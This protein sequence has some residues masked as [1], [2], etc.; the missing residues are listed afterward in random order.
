MDYERPNTL[1]GVHFGP[2]TSCGFDIGWW[3]NELK[4]MG[5]GWIKIVD[6]AGSMYNFAKACRQ[7]G[8][9]P[10]MRMYRKWPN[11]GV[12]GTKDIEAIHIYVR[13]GITRWIEPNNEGNIPPEWAND[14]LPQPIETAA[15]ICAANW[16]IDAEKIIEL[17]GYPGIPALA[18]CSH[19]GECSSIRFSIAFFDWL[20]TNADSRMA[21]VLDHGAWLAVH[22]A[23]LNHAWTD[24]QGWHFEHPYN[25]GLTPFDDDNSLVGYIVPRDLIFA[26]WQRRIP[27]ISTEGGVFHIFRQWD[28]SYPNFVRNSYDHGVW[29]LEM[30]KWLDEWQKTHLW[31]YGMCEWLIGQQILGHQG[32]WDEESWYR[33]GEVRPVVQML[34]DNPPRR[35]DVP[36]PEP[37]PVPIPVPTPI[38]TPTPT[39]APEGFPKPLKNNSLGIH[40]GLGTRLVGAELDEDIVRAKAMR[41][42][43]GTIAF[44]AGE[45]VMLEAAKKLWVAGIMPIVRKVMNISGGYAFG[46]DTQMLVN[47]GIPA[48]VQ[49]FNEPSDSREWESERKQINRY[50][51]NGEVTT[52]CEWWVAGAREVI[53]AGGYPGFQCLH[54][55]ELDTLFRVLPASD[56]IWKRMWFCSHNYGLNH[57]PSWEGNEWGVMGFLLFAEKFQ[58]QLGFV[59]PIICGEG[60]WLWK[61]SDDSNYPMVDDVLHA[62][63]HKEMYEWFRKGR[64]SNG[65]LLPNYLFA[66]CP[67]LI[68]DASDDAWYGYTERTQTINAVKSIP[69]FVRGGEA[70]PEPTPTPTPVVGKVD[71]D[72]LTDEMISMLAIVGP[73]D[74]TKPYWKIT[75]IEIQPDTDKMSMFAVLPPG[76]PFTMQ[77]YWADGQSGW[78]SPKTDFS[79]PVGAREWAASQ[80][81]FRGG[82]GSYGMRLSVNAE[83]L[84]GIGLYQKVDNNIVISMTG[85]HPTLVYFQLVQ[86][87][88]PPVVP[89]VVLPTEIPYTLEARLAMAPGGFEDLRASIEAFSDMEKLQATARRDAQ[90]NPL[91]NLIE[92]IVVHHS[93]N[94]NPHTPMSTARQAIVEGEPT[95]E[96][97]FC[98]QG[99]KISWTARLVWV[100]NHTYQLNSKSI[101]VCILGNYVDNEPAEED[102]AALRFLIASLYEFFGQGWG[103]FRLVGL[104]PHN[105][106]VRNST[107]CPGKVWSKGLWSGQFPLLR[108]PPQ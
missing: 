78:S 37:V 90:G 10:I 54:P 11:P 48:Y 103:K 107:Q 58:V 29:T 73:A 57:P 63:Y 64:L 27:T 20:K 108:T 60:G 43:W 74:P 68:A 82:W 24:E 47:A 16:I 94:S 4:Q 55:H 53:A 38:P 91:W 59:P 95:I 33:V 19:H 106:V 46:R 36:E 70:V 14:S 13:E 22:C 89:P 79:E 52:W 100:T 7:A 15:R 50:G 28:L 99:G 105:K 85:H 49:I 1:R 18:Q 61:A 80:P 65:D 93:G 2:G 104:V 56:P 17:G 102:L 35:L 8:I 44:G 69:E 84:G 96:Y 41:I 71:Y 40:F 92:F 12:L 42:R 101:G 86:P 67:W 72:G 34:K 5:M 97:H 30:Y 39:P 76:V 23:V 51:I 26:R 77:M 83:S 21:Y 31:W 32:I 98:I 6:D 45:D 66:V 3:V 9:M 75:R 88:E 25:K 81:I 87:G 62:A